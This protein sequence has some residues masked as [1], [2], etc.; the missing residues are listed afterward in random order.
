MT[1]TQDKKTILVD[2]DNTLALKD[3]EYALGD[4]TPNGPVIERVRELY[5]LGHTVIVWT[6]RQ[7][8]DA[9]YVAGYCTMH[10]IPYHGLQMGKGGGDA[11]LDDK[12]VSVNDLAWPEHLDAVL[13]LPE[14]ECVDG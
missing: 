5:F 8:S 14:S 11:M 10:D 6:A 2:F 3:D 4:E 9:S 12:A 7:W 13:G 1:P